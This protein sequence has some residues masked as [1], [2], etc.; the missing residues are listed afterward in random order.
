VV[1]IFDANVDDIVRCTGCCTHRKGRY[2]KGEILPLGP[3]TEKDVKKMREVNALY[4]E[5]RAWFV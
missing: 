3:V 4:S 5:V 2:Q 1:Y